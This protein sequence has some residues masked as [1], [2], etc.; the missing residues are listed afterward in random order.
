MLRQI[1]K[2]RIAGSEISLNSGSNELLDRTWPATVS[3]GRELDDGAGGGDMAIPAPAY[4]PGCVRAVRPHAGRR[5]MQKIA[6][7]FATEVLTLRGA[8]KRRISQD[9]A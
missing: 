6:D 2:G 5:S 3:G 9:E 7:A 4:P 1:A 8:A